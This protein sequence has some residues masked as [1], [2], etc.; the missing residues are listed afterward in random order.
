MTIPYLRTLSL[1]VR[2]EPGVLIRVALVFSRRGYNI[3][4]LVVSPGKQEGMS[5][6]TITCSGS[7]ENFPQIIKQLRKLVDVVHATDHTDDDLIETEVA[8]VKVAAPLAQRTTVLQVA[9]HFKAKV[10]DFTSESVVL[11]IHGDTA[12][13]NAALQLL[14]DFEIVETVRS[15]KL[16][17]ARGTQAT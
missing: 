1:L 10:V 11:R 8:L 2:N 14:G 5:R 7:S 17:M 13:L 9:E 16:V 4:S 3:E 6:M 15:G 12:K